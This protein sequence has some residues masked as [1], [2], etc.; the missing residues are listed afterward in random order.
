MLMMMVLSSL[1]STLV[2]FAS[3]ATPSGR[4]STPPCSTRNSPGS[5]A[6]RA[7]ISW[8][9]SDVS[10]V[11]HFGLIA[12]SPP[13]RWSRRCTRSGLSP[14]RG[15]ALEHHGNPSDTVVLAQWM[16]LPVLW[17]ENPGEVRMIVEGDPHEV[18]DLALHGLGAGPQVEQSRQDGRRFGHLAAN[19]HDGRRVERPKGDHD[20]EPLGGDAAGKR[21]GG[22]GE[23]VHGA[24]V[25]AERVAVA[26]EG[27]D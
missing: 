1:I 25:A 12:L 4:R 13:P 21:P 24:D 23:I 15:R 22:V 20:F 2:L 5:V 14:G 17:K 10:S 8:R 16:A 7:A 26:L 18:V 27:G 19:P 11:L 3:R 9:P 6:E